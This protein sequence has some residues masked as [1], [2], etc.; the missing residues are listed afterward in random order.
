MELL[1]EKMQDGDG[2]DDESV[3]VVVVQDGDEEDKEWNGGCILNFVLSDSNSEEATDFVIELFQKFKDG[4]YYKKI[5]NAYPMWKYIEDNHIDALRTYNPMIRKIV[6]LHIFYLEPTVRLKCREFVAPNLSTRFEL[7]CEFVEDKMDCMVRTPFL[8]S[9]INTIFTIPVKLCSLAWLVDIFPLE[10]SVVD[11]RERYRDEERAD[12]E[13]A[14]PPSQ[15]M[16]IG[17]RG[18]HQSQHSSSVQWTSSIADEKARRRAKGLEELQLSRK[19]KSV[20]KPKSVEEDIF[21][22]IMEIE[23]QEKEEQ[24]KRSR[25]HENPNQRRDQEQQH[26]HHHHHNHHRHHR[27]DDDDDD[28]IDTTLRGHE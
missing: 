18:D 11:L 26:T 24:K 21:A 2:G 3:V 8:P 16:L 4:N 1:D 19:A 28:P 12:D 13:H 23:R 6:F 9:N 14:V 25:Y 5:K 22:R 7:F 15:H 20:K 10:I 27:Q 17:R